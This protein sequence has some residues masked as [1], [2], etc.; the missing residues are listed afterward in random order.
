VLSIL[1]SVGLIPAILGIHIGLFLLPPAV[2]IACFALTKDK[3]LI[4]KCALGMSIATLCISLI[5]III[6][7]LVFTGAVGTEIVIGM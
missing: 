7:A 6:I 3:K 5:C 2:I 1:I 4:G